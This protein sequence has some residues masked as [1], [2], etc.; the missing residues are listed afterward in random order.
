[1]DG[2]RA[3]FREEGTM[4]LRT[5]LVIAWVLT[6]S[7]IM[8]AQSPAT[9]ETTIKYPLTEREGPW[10]IHIASFRGDQSLEFAHRL[11]EEARSK[12]RLLTF[13]YSMNEKDAKADREQLR[14]HQIKMIGSDKVAE[15]EE[16]QKFKTV[17]VVKEYSVFVGN[18]PDMEKARYEAVRIKEFAPPSSIP[19]YGV[20]LYKEPTSKA[21]VDP[22]SSEAGG[23]FGM[24]S[25]VKTEEGKRLAETQGNPYRQAFVVRNPMLAKLTQAPTVVTQQSPAPIDPAWRELNDKEK[26]SIFTCA[27]PW[28]L[29][30][31]KFAPPTEVQS[32]IHNSVVQTGSMLPAQNL[33]KGLEAAAETARQMAELLRD[34]GKGYDTYVFHTRQYSLVTVGA[35]DSR[36]DPKMEQAWTILKNF[37]ESQTTE[38]F[39]LLLKLPLPMQVPGK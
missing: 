14:Q 6:V 10:L 32:S 4:L 7:L 37:A 1:M 11:A 34:G 30:V 8:Q 27:K 25:S 5:I 16:R 9:Q 36:F 33:G 13:I 39:S 17:R 3:S 18:F 12:H 19:A 28:T 22:Q 15:S 20:H 2:L 38:P 23:L 31:A 29:V 24:K 26:H 21:R 35:F